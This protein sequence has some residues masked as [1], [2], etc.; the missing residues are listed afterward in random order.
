MNDRHHDATTTQPP[1]EPGRAREAGFSLLELVISTGLSIGVI[2]VTLSFLA[3]SARIAR[4]QTQVAFMQDSQRSGQRELMR[5]ARMAGRGGLPLGA[6]PD[7]IAVT[8]ENDT[9]DDG[10]R[11][12]IARGDDDSPA[13]L[14]GTDVLVVRGVLTTPIYLANPM[15][16]DFTLDDQETPTSGVLRLRDPHPVTAMPQDLETI[17]SAI[18]ADAH[19]ALLLVSPLD[20]WAVVEIDVAASSL[21]A[22]AGEIAI[23]FDIGD[24]DGGDIAGAYARLSGGFPEMLRTVGTAGLLEEHRF[25][26]REEREREGDPTSLLIARLGLLRF[27]PGTEIPIPVNDD[28]ESEIAD[29]IIDL[30][31][32]LGVDRDGDGTVDEG[33][34]DAGRGE[35]EWLFNAAA[36]VSSEGEPVEPATWNPA[37]AA[38]RYL[39]VT[40]VVA[41]DRPELG[42]QA[43]PMERVEDRVYSIDDDAVNSVAERHFRRRALSTVIDMRNL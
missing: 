35:D 14:P 23:A 34:D 26:V 39:R 31:V 8:V 9:P 19:P 2:A 28:F 3:S 40:T 25:Y 13:V 20:A 17:A 24:P 7:G 6:L 21:D 33:E 1:T 27:Y 37:T 16:A 5:L 10:E 32:A 38:V 30:Q 4:S 12:H 43:A 11:R 29:N 42:Y 22:S 15:G 18:Q 36:D 41:T